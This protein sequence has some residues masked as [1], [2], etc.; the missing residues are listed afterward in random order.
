MVQL[1]ADRRDIDFVL[2]EQH[3]AAKLSNHEK[4]IDF[5]KKMI[6]MVI[7]ES[8]NLSLKE[9][10]PTWKISDEMGCTFENGRVITPEGFKHAW[11]LLVDGGWFAMD[12]STE[13]DGQGMPET[14]GMA[15]REYLLGAN[16]SLMMVGCLNR[17][18]GRLIE[19]FGTEKQKALYLKK[20]YRGE[21]GATMVLTEPEAGS[22][23]SSLTTIAIRNDD[24]TYNLT[25]NKIF[26]SGGDHDM[27]ENI[28][29]PVLARIEGAPSGSAGVSLFLAPKIRVNDDG[30]LGEPNDIVCTGIEEKMGLHGSPTCAMALGSKGNCVGTLL[31]KENQGL[32]AMFQMMNE[33][34]LITGTQGLACASASFMHALAYARTRIQGSTPGAGDKQQVTIIHHPDVRRMLL[35]MKMYVEGMR[36]LLYFIA[37]CEDKKHLTESDDERQTY[38]N[39]I[40]I[41]IPVGKAY[42][43]DRA[44]DVCSLG[45]QVF[46]G[47]GYTSEY[48][49]E[50]LYRDVRVVP[51]YEGTNGIQ[52]MDLLGR[53]LSM[54]GGRLFEELTRRIH[55]AIDAARNIERIRGLAEK[56][57]DAVDHWRKAAN[58]LREKMSGSE[59]LSAFLHASP[60]MEVTGD[61]V[62][63]WMMLW[64]AQIAAQQLANNP[65]KKDA[66][67]YQGQLFSAENFIRTVLPVTFGKMASIGDTCTAAIQI[68][69]ESFGGR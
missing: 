3:E 26:I 5:N 9:I 30:S 64:R 60:F 10:H 53:K 22:D 47:Y 67:F 52:A 48:P 1:I 62:F 6:D 15:A 36:S 41:L 49:V 29:H 24:G 31:G 46:G 50:Q 35:T 4:F 34:R 56:V 51:I 18:T 17:G 59:L 58:Q 13:W 11:D 7:T 8:R 27:S 65:K 19:T 32:A 28:I 68:Q 12:C 57:K 33:T 39:L 42:V 55:E 16:L 54:K 23:L 63:S 45:V 38:Q 20:V 44:V 66:L 43:S 21:W 37:V 14:V 25:G 61:V 2:Y 69:D 40:D